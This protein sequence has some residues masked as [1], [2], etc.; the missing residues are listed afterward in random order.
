MHI[1]D[2]IL[3]GTMCLATS[4]AAAVIT[5]VTLKKTS[6]E[7]I[8][9][10]AVMTAAF[11]VA[12]LLHI[13]IGP[14][15]SHLVLNGLMGIIL[16]AGAF[17]AILVSLLYQFLLFQH[18]G[19]TTLGANSLA[20]GVPALMAFILFNLIIK[21]P[22]KNQKIIY[23]IAAFAAAFFA[24]ILSAAIISLLLMFTGEE[25]TS[26]IKTVL[27][28]HIPLALFEGII[29]LFIIGFLLKIKPDVLP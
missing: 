11:F 4:G 27:G 19:I 28:I 9:R 26:I 8:P 1:S 6:H 12:S 7:E 3:S 16:G 24:V 14:V 25:Y 20:M 2:G 10:I 15:S 29:T 22:I 5:T 18:G 23:S 21:I 13:K 17:P